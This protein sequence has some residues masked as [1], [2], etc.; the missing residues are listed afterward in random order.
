MR[1]GDGVGGESRRIRKENESGITK[2]NTVFQFYKFVIH[3]SN[4]FLF[5]RFPK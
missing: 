5:D 1:Q 3:I 2:E 4:C